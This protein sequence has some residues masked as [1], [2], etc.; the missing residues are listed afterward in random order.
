MS[1]KEELENLLKNIQEGLKKYSVK[2]L[3]DAIIHFLGKKHDKTEEIE[4]ILDIIA[5]DYSISKR[6]LKTSKARGE[7]Q[8]AK[9]IA[10][11]LLHINLGLPI[12]YIAKRI[13]M[14]KWHNSVATG[15]HRYKRL[16]L[17]VKPDRQ[18]KDKYD[19]F[20]SNLIDYITKKQ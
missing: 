17:N 10:Y 8:D 11:C 7:I 18:F 19:Q 6:T 16:N 9:Q 5:T 1:D 13:F 15:I 3:N 12:R 4:H 20:S 2:E 14:Y